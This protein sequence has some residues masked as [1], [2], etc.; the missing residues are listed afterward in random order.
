MSVVIDK[1]S[2][3]RVHYTTKEGNKLSFDVRAETPEDAARHVRE[4]VPGARVLK[5]K[6][7]KGA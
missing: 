6:R 3:F 7:L 2:T 5:I 4:Y 1:A